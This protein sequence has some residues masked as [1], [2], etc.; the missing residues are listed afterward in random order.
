MT[1]DGMKAPV[2]IAASLGA[3][4]AA[5]IAAAIMVVATPVSAKAH[6]K[7]SSH[8][9]AE[10]RHPISGLKVISLRVGKGAA[11]HAFRVEVAA[12]FDEQEK[13]LMFRKVLGPAEGMI[14]PMSPAR[15]AAFWMKNTVIP[16]DI[17]FIGP[18][19]R[20]ANVAANAKPYDLTPLYSAGPVI[21]VLEIAGGRAAQLGIGTGDAVAW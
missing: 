8:H 20:I 14:F 5:G 12:S 6:H 10:S 3:V 17:I 19:H 16:L 4:V 18:D 7:G 15:P 9:A 2:R 13:G 11:A 1:N 21:G